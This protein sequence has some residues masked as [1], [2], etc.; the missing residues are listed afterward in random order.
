[1]STDD[2]ILYRH[3]YRAISID[4]PRKFTGWTANANP[5]S[6]RSVE[7]HYKV[8]PRKSILYMCAHQIKQ[9]AHPDGC[10]IFNWSSSP[11]LPQTLEE[12]QAMGARY[13]SI[14]FYWIKMRREFGDGQIALTTTDFDELQKLMHTGLGHT[15]RKN[16]EPVVLGRIGSPSRKSKSVREL[17][18]EPLRENSR[19]PDQFY[20]RVMKY[21][22]GP[23]LDLF[24]RFKRDGWT[25]W[26]DED[27]KFN[28]AQAKPNRKVREAAPPVPPD[29]NQVVMFE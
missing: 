22:E 8:M 19:K 1:M 28:E 3:H 10:H 4:F 6:D 17:I 25:T 24:S 9:L 26:G 20:E 11:L 27:G 18:F 14:A 23:Y 29:P 21:C 5:D 13:S 12:L 2:Q 15:T 7:K 16:I